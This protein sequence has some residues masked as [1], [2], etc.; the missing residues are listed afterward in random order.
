MGSSSSIYRYRES[1]HVRESYGATREC[2]TPGPCPRILPSTR[3]DGSLSSLYTRA[4]NR[5][6]YTQRKQ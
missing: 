6:E 5:N 1:A 3:D 2:I 4:K